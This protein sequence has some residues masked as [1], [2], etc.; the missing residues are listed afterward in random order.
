MTGERGWCLWCLALSLS[1]DDVQ[2]SVVE[3]P[4]YRCPACPARD[5]TY[6]TTVRAPQYPN[7]RPLLQAIQSV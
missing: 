3:C 5:L 1:G 2:R 6:L 4:V 7:T